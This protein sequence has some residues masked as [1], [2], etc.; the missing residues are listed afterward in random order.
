MT[1]DIDLLTSED[2]VLVADIKRITA[3]QRQIQPDVEKELERFHQLHAASK[4]RRRLLIYAVAAA[5]AC[6]A[7][8]VSIV[9]FSR[10]VKN[11]DSGLQVYTAKND[12]SSLTININGESLQ[13]ETS[14]EALL[15]KGFDINESNITMYANSRNAG[16]SSVVNTPAG[17][18]YS[19][20]L[21]DGTK[22]TLN[23]QSRLTIPDSYDNTHREVSLEGEAYFEVFHDTAHPFVVK[24]GTLSVTA[25][26]TAFNVRAYAG[27]QPNVA[28]AE[29]KI[30]VS[31]GSQPPVNVNPGEQT[32]LRHDG[33]LEISATDVNEISEWKNGIFYFDNVILSDIMCELGR[34]YNIS[35]RFTSKERMSE[36]LHFVA[37]RTAPLQENL[38][39]FNEIGIRTEVINGTIVIR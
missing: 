37:D 14:G 26:G 23:A 13:P 1:K 5:A 20:T 30:T 4:P 12:V 9:F 10:S 31:N 38:K 21:P 25:T 19:V 24:T 18:L 33:K 3:Q 8:L 11:T 32:L 27:T 7:V 35:V 34:W 17:K 16:D 15:Q 36:K 28:L 29:G 2:A 22:V 39:N 6:A